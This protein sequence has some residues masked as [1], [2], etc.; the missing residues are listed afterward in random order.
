MT[1]AWRIKLLVR[2]SL[3]MIVCLTTYSYLRA[4]V[5]GR[6]NNS[7]NPVNHQ[8][9]ITYRQ[10]RLKPARRIRRKL[11]GFSSQV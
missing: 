7:Q 4:K 9:P 10:F 3:E 6:V 8:V 11:L 2:R 1:H 5:V